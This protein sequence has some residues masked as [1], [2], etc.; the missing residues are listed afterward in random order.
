M[1]FEFHKYQGTGNDFI[2]I[3]DSLSRFPFDNHDIVKRLCDRHFGIGADGLMLVRK[4]KEHGYEMKYA[5]SDGKESTMCGNGGRCFAAF[6]IAKDVKHKSG[7]VKFLAIDGLHEAH[8]KQ[9]GWVSLKMNDVKSLEIIDETEYVLNTGSPHV[10]K[11]VSNVDEI[12]LIP[13]AHAIRYN[14]RFKEK[15]ININFMTEELHRSKAAMIDH[16]LI[17]TPYNA[18]ID[19]RTYERGVENETLSCGTGSVAAAL[20]KIMLSQRHGNK[21]RSGVLVNTKGGPLIVTAKMPSA[22]TF[23]E[24][25]LEGFTELVFKGEI[26]I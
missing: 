6:L 1:S 16:T 21:E 8:V 11:I 2:I 3:Y 9:S 4:H 17:F 25:H 13:A 12:D 20:I 10:V 24:I 19:V 22:G 14:D 26:K 15:G 18:Q 7:D 23:T 5:N